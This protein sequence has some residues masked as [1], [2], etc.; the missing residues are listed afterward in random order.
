MPDQE[1]IY[2]GNVVLDENNQ[3]MLKQWLLDIIN[4]LQGHGNG[5]DADTVDGF[6]ADAFA[7]AEQGLKAETALQSGIMI[8]SSII[9]NIVDAQYILTDGIK[10]DSIIYDALT[11]KIS[12]I[13]E[14]MILSDFLVALYNNYV[15]RILDLDDRK[16]DKIP[17][18]QLS[19]E[20]FTTEHKEIVEGIS[21]AYDD[22]ICPRESDPSQQVIKKAL[23]ADTVNH[24]QFILTTEA[25]YAQYTEDVKNAWNNVFIF[26]EEEFYPDDYESPLDC[27]I[28]TG[29][30]FRIDSESREGEVWLQY[31]GRLA[32]RWLDL[33]QINELYSQFIEYGNFES[34]MQGIAQTIVDA[35]VEEL[36]TPEHINSL[37]TRIEPPSIDD[38]QSYP[39]L[40]SNLEFVYDVINGD[41]SQSF[42]YKDE[43]GFL[44]ADISSVTDEVETQ[45]NA[46]TNQYN[47]L[48]QALNRDYLKKADALSTY[49]KKADVESSLQNSNNPVKNS[50][51]KQAVDNLSSQIASLNTNIVNL[52]NNVNNMK[53]FQ[54]YLVF[55]IGKQDG[56]KRS[57]KD[58]D[59]YCDILG[60]YDIT[61]GPDGRPEEARLRVSDRGNRGLDPDYIFV[62]VI[63]EHT[64]EDPTIH[65]NP[66]IFFQLNGVAYARKIEAG[67]D[68]AVLNI[69]LPKGTYQIN[70][71]YID[72]SWDYQIPLYASQQI[73]VY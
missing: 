1:R 44:I 56:Q 47:I 70:A 46:L 29:Y 3:E 43:D 6:H 9:D 63:Q 49:V 72:T 4:A 50:V 39:F 28:E 51:I 53:H 60:A 31:K 5:F 22:I 14:D 40:S 34:I 16:V 61:I 19:T 25:I 57:Y 26:I 38:W 66:Y 20:D 37:I 52:R 54:K 68:Y 69:R 27:P 10:I 64:G 42:C 33:I 23:N 8:G 73:L 58:V 59:Q 32:R 24:L 45:V 11:D 21:L 17:G 30:V 7:T 2:I 71:L 41:P 35:T 67:T 36:D 48:S 15:E 13:T 18:K 55:G 65:T 12:T 62:R